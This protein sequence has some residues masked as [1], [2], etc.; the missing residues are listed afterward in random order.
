MGPPPFQFAVPRRSKCHFRAQLILGLSRFGRLVMEYFDFEGASHDSFTQDDDVASD[1]LE[2]DEIDAIARQ[3]SLML[4]QSLEGLPN[5]PPEQDATEQQAP[6]AAVEPPSETGMFPIVR[7]KEP[8]D[9]CARMG[10]DCFVARRGV[11]Q[12]ACTCCISLYRECSFTTA[13]KP[14]KFL[15]TLHTVSEN[16]DIP[17]GGLTGKRAMKSLTGV[18]TPEEM[19]AR[20]KKN[21]ARL[22]REAVR[23]LKTWLYNHREHPYPNEQEK[24][25]LKERTGLKRT[26]ISNWL[27]NARRRS[28]VRSAISA[29]PAQDIPGQEPDMSLMTPMERWKHSPPEHEPAAKSDILRALMTTPLDPSKPRPSQPVGHVRSLSRKTGSSNDDSSLANSNRQPATGSVSSFETSHSSMSDFSFA[30]AFSHRSSLGSFGSMER[31]DRRRRRKVSAPVNEFAQQKARSARIFQCTFCADSFPTKYDWQR[32]E[33]SLHLALEKWTCSPEGGTEII[34]G[35]RRCVFCMASDPDDD[36]LI[37]H[38]FSLCHEKMPHE[39]TFFRKDHLNQHLRL[40]HNVKFHPSMDKWRSTTTEIK[41]RCGFCSATFTTWKERVD[42]LAAHFKNGA[43]MA[44]WQGDWGFEP[45]VQ[46]RV[47][48]AVPPYLIGHERKTP[49][50]FKTSHAMAPSDSSFNGFSAGLK[51]R[52][53]DSNCYHRLQ[54][55]LTA[56][57]H[58]SLAA[59]ISP[60]DQML[61]DESRRIIY[62]NDDPWNQTGAD[63]PVWLNALK[64]DTG[65][66]PNSDQ[67]QFDNLGM[68]PPFAA[69]GGLRQ[70]PIETNAFPRTT[71]Q[72]DPYS[73]RASLSGF[74]SPALRTGRSSTA[75][76]A[77]GSS[78]GSYA[79]STGAFPTA[80]N[81]RTSGEWGGIHSAGISSLS[82]PVSGSIDPFAQMEFD[83]QFMQQFDEGYDGLQNDLEGLTFEGLEDVGLSGG[84]EKLPE[85][86]DLPSFPANNEMSAPIDIPSPKQQ[87]DIH[88]PDAPGMVFQYYGMGDQEMS[89]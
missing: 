77:P 58:K 73:P 61:Q 3:D 85:S 1:Q 56:Y 28:K 24:E 69:Q 11:M 17:T 49:N 13:K 46:S 53:D 64:R 20:S 27:A 84:I 42:H 34:D 83:P 18:L 63:N 12:K 31:K 66:I 74:Q 54:L 78:S 32:H 44:Q 7:T 87:S 86:L 21:N 81:P 10:F 16:V 15:D 65:L 79:C 50:P 35:T 25:E 19:E 29:S 23:V 38:D 22:S 8:C 76:S 68:Q 51:G 60:T 33:K 67:I 70:P 14:G 26:Q 37:S 9:F 43:D 52:L 62:G 55:E 6:D 45:S 72:Q 71:Y 57:I 36:H 88:A 4:D 41:S 80:S 40:M 48:S 47:E 30:S 5:D 89:H 39:R 59:G 82:T 2:L 75:A